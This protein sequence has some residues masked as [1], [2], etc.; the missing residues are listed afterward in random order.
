MG[1]S[2][3]I[4]RMEDEMKL[5]REKLVWIWERIIQAYA[6]YRVTVSAVA[7]LTIYGAVENFLYIFDY[8][9]REKLFLWKW[10]E[11][12]EEISVGLL[13][14]ICGAMFIESCFSYTQK[15]KKV[16]VVRFFCFLAAAVVAFIVSFGIS[17]EKSA[18]IFRVS[19][20]QIRGWSEQ[21]ALGY[22][23]L[24]LLGTVYMC[25]RKSGVEFA[26]YMLHVLANLCVTTAVYIVLSIG[27][28]HVLTVVDTLF[29]DSVLGSFATAGT[30]LLTGLYYVPCCITA[31]C[32]MDSDIDR[33]PGKY[34][35]RDVITSL[36]IF[37]VM[38]VYA[39]LFKILLLWEMPS[40]EVFGIITGI[41]CFGMPIW[42][43]DYYYQ[44]ETRYMRI[45]QKL[46]YAL[47][48]LIPV[49]TYAMGVRI[50]E[51]GMT[52]SRYLGMLM[53]I[54]EIAVLFVWHFCRE[55][56][57][58]VLLI[59][60]VCVIAAF[61]VPGVNRNSLSDRW[62]R[63]FLEN[64]YQKLLTQGELT[65]TE[66]GRLK[67]AYR[68]LK[69][70]PEMASVVER[71]NIY[72][73]SFA[74]KLAETG[75]DME[76]YTQLESHQIHCCQ[77]VGSLD[78]TGYENFDMLN[79][80]LRYSGAK[81][82]RIPVDFSAFR[83]YKRETGTAVT[84]DIS[85]FANRCMAYEKEHP[86]A[87]EEEFTAAMKP[88]QK[89]VLEDDRVLYL[90]HFE[91]RYEDGIKDG[92]DYF[93]IES[94]NISGMLLEKGEKRRN[95]FGLPLMDA[96]VLL[97]TE[98][99]GHEHFEEY[100]YDKKGRM[101]R[102]MEGIARSFES[103]EYWYDEAGN[104][105][106][107]TRYEV[108]RKKEDPEAVVQNQKEWSD[109]SYGYDEAGQPVQTEWEYYASGSLRSVCE[110]DSE[111]ERLKETTYRK[112]GQLWSE[113]V[114]DA[115]KRQL[116][117]TEYDEK[118]QVERRY[119]TDYD[120]QGNVILNATY[121]GEGN[122]IGD[123]GD[124]DCGP[125]GFDFWGRRFAYEFDEDGNLIRQ[126]GFDEQG[127]RT[128]YIEKSYD[129]HG[130]LISEAVY[131]GEDTQMYYEKNAYDE[132]DHLI[133]HYYVYR[134]ESGYDADGLGR[135]EGYEYDEAGRCIREWVRSCD[136]GE[137]EE[138]PPEDSV[139]VRR[140]WEYDEQGRL[141]RYANHS[142][143]KTYNYIY[144]P[145]GDLD[146]DYPYDRIK[147]R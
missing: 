125:E 72:E 31:L 90:N 17:V 10:F 61:L 39:Y 143:E 9:M 144:T 138:I 147:V 129:E 54:I 79:Q 62:Q 60:G 123:E 103:T 115:S 78:V 5:L 33:A 13:L 29:V 30:I 113:R 131:D 97:V 128:G 18:Q 42:V 67:G 70:K 101:L 142:D 8:E 41:F 91:I 43:M 85:D 99:K 46:P 84:V 36:T 146:E 26:E 21:F 75:M 38:V 59:L 93:E 65:Q 102:Y 25:H 2:D 69:D 50:Y 37:A 134:K 32:N 98:N 47:I 141:I 66:C 64:Y 145:V 87:D 71:Y 19:G 86:D 118:E 20:S 104:C 52:P 112:S 133:F 137:D 135:K 127:N 53:V 35:L 45:L 81:E 107:K 76:T 22:V 117:L 51:H 58:R 73:E 132:K 105:M 24:L 56:M 140:E 4:L 68:Y 3:E 109:Y 119:R 6:D 34:L 114:Y 111:G 100:E 14:F 122:E 57:E 48:P 108:H 11:H 126:T 130:N 96:T 83:F 120:E 27:V 89:I 116:W 1:V 28:S 44:D 82:H 7:L 121:D 88:Y 94:V 80:N 16:R 74:A 49:Q 23:L 12:S 136:E 63:A 124:C 95:T 92:E 55:S 139:Y 77:M 110:R 40:N 15:E 106:K